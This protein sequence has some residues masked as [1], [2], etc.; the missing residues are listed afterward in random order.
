MAPDRVLG[1]HPRFAAYLILAMALVIFGLSIWVYL[2]S[3]RVSD[4]EAIRRAEKESAQARAA[5][6]V[7]FANTLVDV[8]ICIP[9]ANIQ[10]ILDSGTLTSRERIDR[11]VARDRYLEKLNELQAISP[12]VK[13]CGK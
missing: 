9:L 7:R 1:K 4:G 10:D 5:L 8:S 13:G 2:L 11:I 12:D 3:G 6:G